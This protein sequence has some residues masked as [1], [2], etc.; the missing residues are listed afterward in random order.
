[1]LIPTAACTSGEQDIA[2]PTPPSVVDDRDPEFVSCGDITHLEVDE[3]GL[4]L[5]V[6]GTESTVGLS[7]NGELRIDVG[8]N[9]TTENTLTPG[10]QDSLSFGDGSTIDLTW[11]DIGWVSLVRQC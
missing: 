1:M 6:E 4:V 2:P 3:A 9:G 11:T 5:V 10:Q 7:A 8:N